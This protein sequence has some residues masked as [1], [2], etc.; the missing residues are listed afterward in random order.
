M[1]EVHLRATV[2]EAKLFAERVL[3]RADRIMTVS[4]HTK[5]DAVRI[6]GLPS[7]RIE[8]V[9]PAAADTY[10]EVT[11]AAGD[12]VR[13]RYGLM[14]PY[15]LS[16][17]TREPRKNL[18]RLIDA[19]EALPKS[20]REEFELLFVG[21]NGWI[22]GREKALL[23]KPPMGVRSL[24]YV[25]EADLPGLTA[26]A[27]A[28]AYPSLYEGFGLPVVQAMAAGVPVIASTGSALPEVVAGAGLLVHPLSRAELTAGLERLLSSPALRTELAAAGRARAACFRW[29]KNAMASLG[30]FDRVGQ[31]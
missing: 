14:R 16:V 21:P 13:R 9:S 27:T 2:A 18:G 12:H 29:G 15:I 17:G 20:F 3:K 24:G 8:V 10:F 23:E 30:F 11:G 19:Y 25:P 4:E 5:R 1:P 7:D 22:S 6:L 26:G 28:F 31:A